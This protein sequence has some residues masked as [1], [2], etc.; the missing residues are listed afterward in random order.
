M[1]YLSYSS[2]I[3]FKKCFFSV[4]RWVSCISLFTSLLLLESCSSSSA[5]VIPEETGE[6]A[7]AKKEVVEVKAV[8]VQKGV[9]YDELVSNGKLYAK[10][11]ADL[12]FRVSRPIAKIN[13]KNGDMVQKGDTI[14]VLEN[15]ELIQELNQA[16]IN[17]DRAQLDYEDFLLGK[18]F[19][20]GDSA[21]I[22]EKIV[23]NAKIRSGLRQAETSLAMA[24]LNY[25]Q[26]VIVAPMKGIVA[27]LF[28][29][30]MN[31]PL[32]NQPFCSVIDN[33]Y[34]HVEFP[35]L[36][37][38]LGKIG[39]GQSVVVSPYFNSDAE[40]KGIVDII[41]PAINDNGMIVVFG[42]V[43]NNDM[44]LKQGMN[45]TVK[46]QQAMQNQLFVPKQ[47]VTIRSD[48]DVVF[49]VE[50]SSAQWNYVK[51]ADENARFYTIKDGVEEGDWVIVEGNT[52]L[53]NNTPVDPTLIAP[54]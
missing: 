23:K 16:A 3:H 1:L 6:S 25:R 29:K 20:T 24:R 32:G 8:Q 48:K 13:F 33:Q 17:F 34:F 47:A 18:G 11:K 51:I 21:T 45:V 2:C 50:D 26:S 44:S 27:N 9:F 49:T 30:E 28:V 4:G 19:V 42:L 35:V 15:D 37:S 10:N 14:A 43:K 12:Y 41:N 52:H 40:Y 22:P 46:L 39:K 54:H 5:N 53:A 36:E 31:M 7:P 38:E